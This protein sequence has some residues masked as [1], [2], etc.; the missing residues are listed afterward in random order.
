MGSLPQSFEKRH[1]E[2]FDDQLSIR[3]T[4]EKEKNT[5]F[6]IRLR[7]GFS[8]LLA[9]CSTSSRAYYIRRLHKL[10]AKRDGVNRD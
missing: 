9:E 2:T 4:G 6:S 7:F 1:S 5:R 8:T 3:K 10:S